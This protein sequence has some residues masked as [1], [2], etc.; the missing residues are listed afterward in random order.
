MKP[1]DLFY[2]V[3]YI[4]NTIGE[5]M[6]AIGGVFS[7]DAADAGVMGGLTIGIFGENGGLIYWLNDK[8]IWRMVQET[9]TGLSF[10]SPLGP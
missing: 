9:L 6:S 7:A 3:E 5:I 2:L 10:T 1:I 8:I 4:V